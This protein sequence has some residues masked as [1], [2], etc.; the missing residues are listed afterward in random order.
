MDD[1]SRLAD[2][3]EIVGAVI[4]VGGV[5]FAILQM[6][7][8]RQQRRELAAIELF[9]F[10]G[11]PNFADAYQIV[12]HLPDGLSAD[13]IRGGDGKIEEAAMLI[14]TT[15]EN[16]GVMTYQRIVPFAIVNNLVGTSAIILWRKLEN[17][18]LALRTELDEPSAF[19]WFQWLADRLEQHASPADAPAYVAHVDWEPS[20]ITQ[21]F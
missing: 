15:M 21:E 10:F 8:I 12:L 18:A 1:L 4:V 14:S 20:N 9:R 7:Q 13:E 17:W 2:I 3:A 6:R 19:E 16:I 5:F 11:N